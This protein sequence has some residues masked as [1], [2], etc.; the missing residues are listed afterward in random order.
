[1]DSTSVVICKDF[2][3]GIFSNL[4]AVNIGLFAALI[5]VA[6]FVF[7]I[8]YWL[9]TARMK[10]VAEETAQ[11]TTKDT[12]EELFIKSQVYID[13]QIV[14]L[15]SSW[16]R[17]ILNLEKTQNP[18]KNKRDILIL[19]LSEMA[20]QMINQQK[21]QYYAALL[22]IYKDC[23]DELLNA[24]G[25]EDDNDAIT[26]SIKMIRSSY[27]A[28]NTKEEDEITKSSIDSLISQIEKMGEKLKK[29][30]SA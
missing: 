18:S 6:V 28:L 5:A 14:S 30:K 26:E 16:Y 8:K 1:M 7:G 20:N 17:T 4:V 23:L 3:Q 2:F 12:K 13:D 24:R 27:I 15:Y 29:E 22:D 9:D 21:I 11:K 19:M 25:K 10:E